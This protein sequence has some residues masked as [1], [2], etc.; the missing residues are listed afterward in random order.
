MWKWE[1]LGL[2]L[3]FTGG[4]GGYMELIHGL[5]YDSHLNIKDSFSRNR[6]SLII[7][8]F[9]ADIYYYIIIYYKMWSLTPL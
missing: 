7:K 2:N 4:G 1:E 6:F 5:V 8:A 9:L 3:S